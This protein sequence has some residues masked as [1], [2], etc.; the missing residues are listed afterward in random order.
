MRLSRQ[1][2]NEIQK[3]IQTLSGDQLE[4]I[5]ELY[6]NGTFRTLAIPILAEK[7]VSGSRTDFKE[8][9]KLDKEKGLIR[10]K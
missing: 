7:C 2:K 9:M 6:K 10:L 1:P 5:I 8:I 4:P 3:V